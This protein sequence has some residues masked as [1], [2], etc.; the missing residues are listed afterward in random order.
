MLTKAHDPTGR[1]GKFS[2]R[3]ILLIVN[4]SKEKFQS[5]IS[6]N[7]IYFVQRKASRNQ[8]ISECI[9][10]AIYATLTI[11]AKIQ[12]ISGEAFCGYAARFALHLVLWVA[13]FSSSKKTNMA[14]NWPSCINPCKNT[15]NNSWSCCSLIGHKKTK[16]LWHQSEAR[17]TPTVWNWSGKTV[18][19]GAPRFVLYFS[20]RKFFI[21]RYDFPS[22]P[23]TAPGSPRMA[24]IKSY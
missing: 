21:A 7:N 14:S 10:L 22:P 18:S 9:K 13:F 12:R 4:N 20:S 19:P 16:I 23:L 15:R 8:S 17:T 11:P 24:V 6:K 1:S 5:E 2:F 3:L